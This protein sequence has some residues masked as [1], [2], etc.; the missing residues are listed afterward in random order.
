M[1]I[2]YGIIIALAL[3]ACP[4][5]TNTQVKDSASVAAC[6]ASHW[7]ED[8]TQLM[9]H[10]AGPSLDL[11]Y[12]IVAEDEKNAV[13]S[14]TAPTASAKP[15]TQLLTFRVETDGSVGNAKALHRSYYAKEPP[16]A[17]RLRQMKDA[18]GE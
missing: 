10:C 11:F 16:I 7:G 3:S 12:D 15:A 1:R 9:A 5:P 17:S 18:G 8:W 2:F 14:S 6:V 13:A 4:R